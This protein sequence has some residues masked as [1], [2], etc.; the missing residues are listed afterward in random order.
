MRETR[1]RVRLEGGV[2]RKI[3]GR[4]GVRQRCPLSP[5]LFNVLLADMKEEMGKVKW[6]E[7][8]YILWHTQTT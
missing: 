2:G 4:K 6:G 5:L 7:E 8:R 1:S 3:L